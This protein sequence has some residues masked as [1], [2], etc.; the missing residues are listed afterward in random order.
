MERWLTGDGYLV[1]AIAGQRAAFFER[2]ADGEPKITI[3]GFR[4]TGR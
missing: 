3:V 1:S 4:L 2:G